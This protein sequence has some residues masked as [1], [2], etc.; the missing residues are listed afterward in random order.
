MDYLFIYLE[1]SIKGKHL[2][3]STRNKNFLD[4]KIFNK[5]L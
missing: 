2:F 3:T 1:A 5:N 4:I